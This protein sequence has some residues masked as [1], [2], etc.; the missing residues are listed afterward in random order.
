[1]A[2]DLFHDLVKQALINEG[3]T[4]TH[5]PFPLHTRKEGGL[6]TDLGAERIIFAENRSQKIAVEVKS[7][8]HISILHDFSIGGWSILC[9]Q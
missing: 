1:M 8:I 9:L 3:W 5:D 2:R 7:F 4:V 6:S